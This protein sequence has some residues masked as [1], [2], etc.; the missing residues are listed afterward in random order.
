MDTRW[1][2]PLI[3]TSMVQAGEMYKWVDAEG[4]IRYSQHNPGGT[5]QLEKT[6]EYPDYT[7]NEL[8]AKNRAEAL[9]KERERTKLEQERQRLLQEK[10]RLDAEA[11]FAKIQ[12][13]RSLDALEKAKREQKES[14]EF[15]DK[16]RRDLRIR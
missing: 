5:Y 9:K 1:L 12:Y 14:E 2:L 15:L 3:F 16:L 8:E 13:I 11:E 7:P 10:A 4:N 6:I